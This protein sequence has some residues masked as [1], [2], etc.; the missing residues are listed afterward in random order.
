MSGWYEIRASTQ[1]TIETQRD[2]E[3]QKRDQEVERRV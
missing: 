2:E 1:I 3:K